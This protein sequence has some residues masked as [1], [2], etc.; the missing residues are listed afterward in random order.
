MLTIMALPAPDGIC[1]Y[2]S[3]HGAKKKC[4]VKM[5]YKGKQALEVALGENR[6]SS[7]V[8]SITKGAIDVLH[9]LGRVLNGYR[10]ANL[11][12]YFAM[13]PL[14]G[15]FLGWLKREPWWIY[16]ALGLS[17]SVLLYVGLRFD[18]ATPTTCPNGTRLALKGLYDYATEFCVRLG[19]HTGLSYVGV[20]F[21]IFI[22]GMPLAIVVDLMTG[23]RERL[24]KR[25]SFD[26]G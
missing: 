17:F 19:N 6:F 22:V 11:W 26:E 4:G 2:A 10:G 23:M 9:S 25:P 3:C 8:H 18:E 12:V 7:M 16:L 13:L 24:P 21:I 20:N 15:L 5:P 1:S 14:A